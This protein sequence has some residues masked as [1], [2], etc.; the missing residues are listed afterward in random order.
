MS[1]RCHAAV[2]TR[3][4]QEHL[5][6]R[7]CLRRYPPG[8]LLSLFIFTMI[9]RYICLSFARD[10]DLYYRSQKSVSVLKLQ[11]KVC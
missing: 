10:I 7:L 1:C 11:K 5:V 9:V 4:H 8:H 3:P 6:Q 2:A